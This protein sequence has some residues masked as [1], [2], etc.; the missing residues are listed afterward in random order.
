METNPDGRLRPKAGFAPSQTFNTKQA[1][2]ASALIPTVPIGAS[3]GK[4]P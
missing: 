2:I 4:S 3:N 1:V